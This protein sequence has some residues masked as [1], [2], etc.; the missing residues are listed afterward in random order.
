[1]GALGRQRRKIFK[2]SGFSFGKRSP[3][4][5]HRRFV[6]NPA[7]LGAFGS[8]PYT[9]SPGGATLTSLRKGMLVAR[10]ERQKLSL[11]S[12]LSARLSRKASST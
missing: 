3:W 7:Q 5:K 12:R 1:M 11:L 9:V 8:Q 2:S 6:K 10:K 4:R